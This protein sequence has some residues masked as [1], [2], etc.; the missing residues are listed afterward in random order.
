M[1]YYLRI[2]KYKDFKPELEQIEAFFAYSSLVDQS[3]ILGLTAFALRTLFD[4]ITAIRAFNIVS[5]LNRNR[6][7]GFDSSPV[8]RRECRG[9]THVACSDDS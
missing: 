7:N 2:S 1:S 9:I 8:S 5:K 3:L 6:F 4:R